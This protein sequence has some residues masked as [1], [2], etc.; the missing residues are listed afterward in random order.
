MFVSSLSQQT[1]LNPKSKIQNPTF[2]RR[3]LFA[4]FALLWMIAARVAG[5]TDLW[6]Y[7]QY[8]TIG[9]TSDIVI[10]GG[11]HWILPMSGDQPA[12][13]PPLYNWIAA[14]FVK[15]LGFNSEIAHK[16]PSLIALCVC[17]LALVRLGQ[18][19][20]TDS[21]PFRGAG[22]LAGIILVAN[23][24]MFKLGYVA[25]PDMLLT[26]WL[27]L[28]WM[29]ATAALI[30][31]AKPPN[32]WLV[33]GF[34]TCIALAALTKG[35]AALVGIVSAFIIARVVGGSWRSI[36]LL[37][38]VIGLPAIVI[39]A[40]AWV[41]GV[42]RIDP[43]H[44]YETLWHAEFY[45][46]ITGTGTEGATG[47]P[48]LWGWFK[49]LPYHPLY[50]LGRFFPWSLCAIAAMIA[51]WKRPSNR[52]ADAPQNALSDTT[53]LWLNSAIVQVIV[54]IALFSLSTGKRADYLAVAFPPA[55][56]LASFWLFRMPPALAASRWWLAPVSAAV[57]LAALTI[58]N[59]YYAGV[60]R[61]HGDHAKRFV[62]Q[63]TAVIADQPHPLV[64]C[65]VTPTFMQAM[66][67]PNAGTGEDAVMQ[68][69]DERRT[70]WIVAGQPGGEGD[71][72]DWLTQKTCGAVPLETR[73]Q[74]APLPW[75][76]ARA[77]RL[78]L[79][80]AR[81]LNSSD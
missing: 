75:R 19:L 66:L 57:V 45:G 12:T 48:G 71:F 6:E 33:A 79:Y 17:W 22:W 81:P 51:L 18:R 47:A 4:F 2:E 78:T 46:R 72:A 38:P 8:K 27:T 10:H 69:I 37:R 20:D 52:A 29:A 50:F 7:T 76:G 42:W 28:A 44:V 56:L 26:M 30:P 59:S 49:S 54:V 70:F 25:R 62:D 35:P 43:N 74:S 68:L 58:N 5:P 14:P 65:F 32:G 64:Y 60:E 39:V 73:A 34:W 3:V 61:A 13:K 53:R 24:T 63:A 55:A 77:E 21:A 1:V 9:Y 23:H 41:Y 11:D 67:G 15:W 36:A 80:L 16:F 40:G 31:R